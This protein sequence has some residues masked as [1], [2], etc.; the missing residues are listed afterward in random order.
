MIV[1]GA[2]IRAGRAMIGWHQREL[3]AAAQ[4]HLNTVAA[5]EKQ[6]HLS[7]E[8]RRRCRSALARIESALRAEGVRMLEQPVVGVGLTV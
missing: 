6:E 7:P 1:D 3:A 2:Q 5:L 8:K 4:V